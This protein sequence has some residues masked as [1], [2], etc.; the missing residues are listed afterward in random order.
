ME[1]Q[2]SGDELTSITFSVMGNKF[3]LRCAK[4]QENDLKKSI[5]QVQSI[6][7]DILRKNPNLSVGQVAILTAI[8]SQ[9]RLQNYLGSSTPF[10]REAKSL[11]R[12]IKKNLNDSRD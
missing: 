8:E 3:T 12:I 10:H 7:A 9:N 6:G 4:K 1:D 11:I 5:E 2:V